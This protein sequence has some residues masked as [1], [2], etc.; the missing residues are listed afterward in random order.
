MTAQRPDRLEY[1]GKTYSVY[2]FI[3]LPPG[4][5]PPP[6]EILVLSTAFWRGFTVRWAIEARDG[7]PLLAMLGFQC[8]E[9]LPLC[10]PYVNPITGT[11][12]VV[13]ENAELVHYEHMGFQSKYAGE[14]RMR[15]VAGELVGIEPIPDTEQPQD[16]LLDLAELGP[17]GQE[18]WIERNRQRL[19]DYVPTPIPPDV[20]AMLEE[21]ESAPRRNVPCS[22]CGAIVAEAPPRLVR[23]FNCRSC[24]ER[25]HE[26][27]RHLRHWHARMSPYGGVVQ[28][29]QRCDAEDHAP[30]DPDWHARTRLDP[31][32]FLEFAGSDQAVKLRVRG[33][34]S[35]QSR[36][37]IDSVGDDEAQEEQRSAVLAAVTARLGACLGDSETTRVW[38]RYGYGITAHLRCDVNVTASTGQG[39]DRLSSEVIA[40]QLLVKLEAAI[41]RWHAEI[42]A[43]DRVLHREVPALVAQVMPDPAAG[44]ADGPTPTDREILDW[45]M[46]GDRRGPVREW[47]VLP[48][49]TPEGWVPGE[50]VAERYRQSLN[51]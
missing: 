21:D 24:A 31:F 15:F 23:E 37:A 10:Q 51:L 29:N 32:A 38:A 8:H 14:L 42:A 50:T 48:R 22:A 44:V 11:V 30:L 36:F 20:R 6:E 27:G 18:G 12:R 45:V 2:E 46:R 39:T 19:K 17:G 40:T 5:V 7:R 28:L 49:H 41:E 33:R 26:I 3:D 13:P 35:L 47:A 25:L 1:D 16:G 9:Y 34:L 43:I 4:V